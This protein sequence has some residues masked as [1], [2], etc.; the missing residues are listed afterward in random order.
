MST[1]AAAMLRVS[2]ITAVGAIIGTAGCS[3]QS[4]NSNDIATQTVALT[5]DELQ[6]PCLTANSECWVTVTECR[7]D[8]TR[9]EEDCALLADECARQ[10]DTCLGYDNSAG[11]AH[12]RIK[13]CTS[14]EARY[15][16]QT[17][18]CQLEP[19]FALVGGGARTLV[20]SDG[21][22][23]PKGAFLTESRPLD[24][25][26]WRASSADHLLRSSHDLVVYAIGL[27]LDGV[28]T[29]TLR[30]SI[31]LKEVQLAGPTAAVH[32][33]DGSML[34]SGGA[35]TTTAPGSAGRLL[36]STQFTGYH[37]WQAGST[38]HLVSAEGTTR[39]WMLE[40]EDRIIEGFGALELRQLIA[41]SSQTTSGASTSSVQLEPGWAL[42]GMGGSVVSEPGGAGRMLSAIAPGEDNRSVNVTSR[43]YLEFSAGTTTAY[44]VM[45]RKVPGS[46]GLCNPGTALKSTMDSCVADICGQRPECCS[47]GWDDSCVAMVEPV[48]GRSCTEHTCVVPEFEPERWNF[49]HGTPEEPVYTTNNNV[50]SNCMY[51]ALNIYPDGDVMHPGS[52]LDLLSSDVWGPWYRQLALIEGQ[53]LIPT[54]QDGQCSE[55]RTKVYWGYFGG[56]AG[57]DFHFKRQDSDGGWSDKMA[58]S[59][60][61]KRAVP[62][63][64]ATG[65]NGYFCACLQPLPA[66]DPPFPQ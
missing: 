59:G 66:I 60:D 26:T 65:G 31:R 1:V 58:S 50:Q 35:A 52:G 37:Q 13:T 47:N 18:D 5:V 23:H 3:S 49:N 38:D 43:D 21:S 57:P 17:V 28:N 36:S 8:E 44:A 53:G 41:H 39:A 20:Y 55:G 12:V 14:T 9:T 11:P 48:C 51:Y 25:R 4:E 2:T 46:H 40:I 30:E 29:Q 33:S 27:R 54:T 10:K 15:G 42:V 19:E 45:V 16:Q 56:P 32:I 22:Y 64:P 24:G 7:S 63:G 62:P 61:V 6:Q 34:L